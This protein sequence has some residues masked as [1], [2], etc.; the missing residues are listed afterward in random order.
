MA[1]D[2]SSVTGFIVANRVSLQPNSKY[3]VRSRRPLYAMTCI[4]PLKDGRQQPM[5]TIL[6]NKRA[7]FAVD[8]VG[9]S[10]LLF[11]ACSC[12]HAC[13][14]WYAGIKYCI[15]TLSIAQQGWGF[16]REENSPH[17]QRWPGTSPSLGCHSLRLLGQ[18]GRC[19]GRLS[20]NSLACKG[21]ASA[22]IRWIRM[23]PLRSKAK[24]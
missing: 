6:R 21:Y 11:L 17:R 12:E 3:Q 24:D 13:S 16:G 1:D 18:R 8:R 22:S 5:S 14:A 19:L 10:S 23:E 15:I 2:V 7:L 9:L 20:M 4:G